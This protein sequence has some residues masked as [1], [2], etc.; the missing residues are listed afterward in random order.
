MNSK[1]PPEY[2]SKYESAAKNN[3]KYIENSK[4]ILDLL[5]VQLKP[6][7]GKRFNLNLDPLIV[8][9]ESAQKSDFLSNFPILSRKDSF[10][11]N[12]IQLPEEEKARLKIS[13][14]EDEISDFF[15][16]PET[17]S[18]DDFSLE[19]D[20]NSLLMKNS[21]PITSKNSILN[22]KK[23]RITLNNL[24]NQFE[25]RNNFKTKLMK[26]IG[27][28]TEELNKKYAHVINAMNT[29]GFKEYINGN[30]YNTL[31]R[32]VDNQIQKRIMRT[33]KQK[34]FNQSNSNFK[35]NSEILNEKRNKNENQSNGNEIKLENLSAYQNKSTKT[36]DFRENSEMHMSDI[37]R[38]T[39][40]EYNYKKNSR[41]RRAIDR[42]SVV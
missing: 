36:P 21:R 33:I 28:E 1:L 8:N 14:Y 3:S 27:N 32:R 11:D 6:F 26:R 13:N 30:I 19:D 22:T 40:F 42:K 2:I 18:V 15:N 12:D 29:S 38:I 25:R 16:E 31:T 10:L 20:F 34:Y 41:M 24:P 37:K 23:D 35:S 9:I 17:K 7:Y 5:N 4:N 39:S